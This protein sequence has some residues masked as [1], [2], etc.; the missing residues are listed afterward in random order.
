MLLIQKSTQEKVKSND[1]SS[2]L[3][4]VKSNEELYYSSIKVG[5]RFIFLAV[6]FCISIDQ[7][8]SIRDAPTTWGAKGS[9]VTR[10]NTVRAHK[11]TMRAHKH[12]VKTH[13]PI[14]RVLKPRVRV[15]KPILRVYEL[16]VRVHKPIMKAPKPIVRAHKPIMR[17]HKIILRAHKHIVKAHKH[18][19]RA[20][21]PIV[22]SLVS[23]LI[24][25]LCVACGD[26][27]V[28]LQTWKCWLITFFT[29]IE[30]EDLF[31]VFGH[32]Y[33]LSAPFFKF[34]SN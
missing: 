9:A 20:H 25:K 26:D 13:K 5:S 7:G 32:Q 18:I 19:V 11:P 31:L 10:V 12:I 8:F 17:V 6:L 28:F 16:M 33:C 29:Q 21:K 3:S 2:C 4:K 14:V 30:G 15:Y 27:S 24:L 34:H 23:F 1:W 22:R